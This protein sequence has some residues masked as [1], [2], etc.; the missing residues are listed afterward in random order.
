[1]SIQTTGLRFAKQAELVLKRNAPT[2]LTGAGVVGFIATTVVTIR[3][4]AKAVDKLPEISKTIREAKSLEVTEEFTEKQKTEVLI[5]GYIHS[6]AELAKIYSPTLALGSISIAC[7]ISGH[8]MMLKRQASLLA[9]YS[10]LDAGF[11]AYRKRVAD[12]I[13][14]DEEL[15]L[16]RRPKMRAL[17]QDEDDTGPPC[18]IIDMDDVMP[19]PYAR[20]FDETS[21][22]WRK[23]PE[24]NLMFLRAQQDWANDKLTSHGYLFLNEVYE[25][26]GLERSQLGQIV[27]WKKKKTGNNDGF[28]DFG[29]YAIGDE[30]NRAFVNLIE[31]TV[32]L[33]FNV[34]GVIKI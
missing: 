18:E 21:P 27:G 22:N 25:A 6:T 5:R 30:C 3:A 19:S 10:A 26:L 14:V 29:L 15:E 17:D 2:I 1:M 28:V 8:G 33:D 32:L 13:G 24:Y 23:T 9:A 20:F 11:R 12:K 16:Y 31:H 7:V 34:D 4:T